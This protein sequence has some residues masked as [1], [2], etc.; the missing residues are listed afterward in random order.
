[1]K[2]N[3]LPSTTL[4]L[5][6]INISLYSLFCQLYMNQKTEASS[7]R[8]PDHSSISSIFICSTPF[9]FLQRHLT[10][11]FMGYATWFFSLCYQSWADPHTLFL[12]VWDLSFKK[13]KAG[14]VKNGLFEIETQYFLKTQWV[15]LSSLCSFSLGWSLVQWSWWLLVSWFQASLFLTCIVR[16]SGSQ[17]RSAGTVVTCRSIHSNLIHLGISWSHCELFMPWFLHC[18]CLIT[19]SCSWSCRPLMAS[20]SWWIVKDGLYLCLRMWP[21]TWVI[22]RKSSWTQVST[23]SCMWET[24]L[25]L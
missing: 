3:R 9:I 10:L 8:H 7:A 25:S 1:M 24:M 15:K 19:S 16:K 11:I 12:N 18:S 13:M 5:S 2:R 22:T 17:D 20:S 6:I 14:I 21:V 4:I 23:A